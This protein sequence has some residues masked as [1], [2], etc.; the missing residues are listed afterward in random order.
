MNQCKDLFSELKMAQTDPRKRQYLIPARIVLVKGQMENPEFLLTEQPTQITLKPHHGSCIFKN[1]PGQEH[2][3]ILLDFGREFMGS[4]RLSAWHVTPAGG[5]VQMRIRLGESAMEAMTPL[6]VKN[7]TNNHAIRDADYSIGEMS[8]TETPQSGFRFAWIELLEEDASIKIQSAMGVFYY[9]DLPYL[10]SFACSDPLLDRIWET[11]AYTVHLNMQE[12]LWDGIKRDRLVWIGDMH[13]EVLTAL[14]VFGFQDVIT[15]SIDF[16]RDE[17]PISPGKMQWMN[18]ISSYS[19]WWILILEALWR[20]VGDLSYLQAQQSYLTV[21][22][23]ALCDVI[24]EDGSEQL[25]A[26]RFLDWPNEANDKAKHAGLQGLLKLG[27]LHGA[28][29]MDALQD[30]DLAKRCRE[31]AKKLDTHLPDPNGS[32][33]AGALLALSGIVDAK[34]INNT[35]LSIGGAH[36]Y[37]T[38]FSYYILRAKALAGDVVGALSDIRSY[39]GAMLELGATTFWEDFDLDW[40][41]NAAPI[42]DIVPDGKD[43]IHG[44]FGKYCYQ[45]FRHSLCHGWASGP[46]PFL[47]DTVLGL[48]L[49]SPDCVLV[50][51]DLGDLEWARGSIPTKYG[52]VRVLARKQEDGSVSTIIHEPKGIRIIRG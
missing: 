39:F 25:P 15:K 41:K 26:W 17:T 29:L 28:T 21:L 23:D 36:G 34:E 47:I 8:S 43:D 38:F 40:C 27:L 9:R 46:C 20:T 50:A 51:P 6:G 30:T 42:T 31:G 11:A 5:R 12:Y 4:L 7:S 10:G 37:S 18:G 24:G 32:K 3:G 48:K 49:L 19:I 52:T 45:N 35:V 13:T 22:L 1:T 14:N 33:Q 44:D 2:A 16:V